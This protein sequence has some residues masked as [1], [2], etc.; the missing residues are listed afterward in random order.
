[1]TI[2]AA[3]RTLTC[4]D[5]GRPAEDD[6]RFCEH[7][8][9]PLTSVVPEP[10]VALRP[11]DQPPRPAVTWA[12]SAFDRVCR[13]C[14]VDVPRGD[15]ACPAC[16]A[17][18]APAPRPTARLGTVHQ[19]RKGLRKRLA[20]RVADT[21]E[22]STLLMA[23]GELR[24]FPEAEVPPPAPVALLSV[25][26]DLRAPHSEL[27]RL[28]RGVDGGEIERSWDPD[29][30]VDEAFAALGDDVGVA[31]LMAVDLLALGAPELVD[32]LPLPA[33]ERSWVAAVDAGGRGDVVAFLQAL[34]ALPPDRYRPKIVLVA[35][36]LPLLSADTRRAVRSHLLPFVDLEPLARILVRADEGDDTLEALGDD[37]AWMAQRSQ[38]HDRH[39]SWGS[40][41]RL[42]AARSSDAPVAALEADDLAV[43]PL[44]V[45]DDLVDR[46]RLGREL[47]AAGAPSEHRSYLLAR[48]APQ[49]LDD[50]ALVD[51]GHDAEQARRAFVAYDDNALASLAPSDA[52]RHY[53][54]LEQLRAG[55]LADDLLEEVRADAR[56]VAARY[57]LLAQA[58][59]DGVDVGA[60]VDDTVLDD[61]T[62]WP[63]LLDLVDARHLQ[64]PSDVLGR[65]PDFV[66]WLSLQQAREC[67]FDGEWAAAVDAAKQCLALARAEAVRDEALNLIACG[68]HHLGNDEAAMRA[69]ESAIE[70]AYSESLLANIG[71]VAAGLA[72]EVAAVHL[73]RLMAEAPTIQMRIAAAR[74]AVDIWLTDTD[75][76]A[77]DISEDKDHIPDVLRD[78]L[79]ALIVSDVPL[80]DFRALLRLASV[81]DEAWVADP[82]N[83]AASPHRDSLEATFY[84]RKARSLLSL[85]EVIGEVMRNG[86]PPAWVLDERDSLR[87]A[88]VEVLFE[89]LDDPNSTFGGVALELVDQGAIEAEYDRVLLDA[90]GL[91]GVAYHVSERE[92]ELVDRLVERMFAM[93]TAWQALA[94]EDRA[95]LDPPVELAI[96]RVAIN[97]LT[98]RQKEIGA[99]AGLFDEAVHL[100]RTAPYGSPAVVRAFAAI[101]E[102]ATVAVSC[103]RELQQFLPVVDHADVQAALAETVENTRTLEAACLDILD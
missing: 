80:D 88:T 67:L 76:W 58:Q 40:R 9:A 38:G 26:A 72:P 89:N 6:S 54:A 11:P 45:L 66:E 63:M 18:L 14:G 7:C 17:P 87:N 28:A 102:V 85:I 96:R 35:R 12:E 47:V 33:S 77:G 31:R 4:D 50:D 101:R 48:V 93:R 95:R 71:I 29:R 98:A 62:L 56:P 90:L 43:A 60:L 13:G 61:R 23:D 64:A 99:A 52:V 59:A 82:T 20:V 10:A 69:L 2:D 27:V 46:D 19:Y 86:A 8:G 57:A 24:R 3:P 37:I 39:D 32:R 55:R 42:L 25:R 65:H 1:M 94:P 16:A 74:R 78:P 92:E 79:R 15:R 41:S 22:G 97:R 91:A 75:L 100:G 103:R 51:L 73:A 84:T 53:R 68:H 44:S 5:C 49:V 83:L 30:L 34:A 70:G 81:K 21:A 36:L